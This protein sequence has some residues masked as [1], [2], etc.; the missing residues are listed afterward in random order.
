MMTKPSR[1]ISIVAALLAWTPAIATA[2]SI[3]DGFY[4]KLSTQFRGDGMKLDVINGGSKNNLTRLEPNQDV[5]G[6]FWRITKAADGWYL[7]STQFRGSNVC[8]DIFN[9]GA[10]DNEAHLTRCENLTGQHWKITGENGAFRLTTEFRGPEMCLDIFNGGPNDNQAHLTKCGNMTGQAWMLTKT[11][12]AV[13]GFAA[14]S[15]PA[16]EPAKAPAGASGCKPN[17]VYS[18]SMGQ[19]IPKSLGR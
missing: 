1:L 8:L 4:Y 13:E 6:Q 19:C 15:K 3:Q 17:E 16:R 18:S 10:N 9:G 12:M 14:D 5:T 11:N 7:L 2:Q